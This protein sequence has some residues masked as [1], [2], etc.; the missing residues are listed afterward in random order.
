MSRTRKV[1]QTSEIAHLWANQSVSEARNP[2]YNFYFEGPKLYSY[3]RHYLAGNLIN[4][5]TA[6]INNYN[7]SVTTNKH[8]S[9]AYYALDRSKFANYFFLPEPDVKIGKHHNHIVNVEYLFNAIKANSERVKTARSRK[10]DYLNAIDSNKAEIK[11]YC[12]VF[13]CKSVLTTAHK[14][15]LNAESEHLSE[16]YAKLRASKIR[17][18]KAIQAKNERTRKEKASIELQKWLSFEVHTTYQQDK[19]YLRIN[20]DVIETTGGVNIPL[21]DAKLLWPL[22]LHSYKNSYKWTNEDESF[23]IGYYKLNFI[24][25]NGD[26]KAGCHYIEF[27]ELLKIAETLGLQLP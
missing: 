14:N 11:L 19:I 12:E 22:I 18:N 5:N 27:S 1:F 25:E 17:K 16:K 13:K 3:G 2:T 26:I 6:I 24:Y 10:V 15:I 20:E 9:N 23:K 21:S 8:T 7:Y 4:D